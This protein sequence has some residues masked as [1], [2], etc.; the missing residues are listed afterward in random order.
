MSFP[1]RTNWWNSINFGRKNRTL[2]I[3][4][5]R[6]QRTLFLLLCCSF[7]YGLLTAG[8]ANI[9]PP[10]GGKKDETPPVLLSISPADSALNIRPSLIELKFNKFME[11]KDLNKYMQLSPLL[12]IQPTV[13]S[14]LRR[15]E[16]KIVDSLLQPNTTYRIDLGDALVDNREATPYKNFVYLFSTGNY[17]DSLE[18]NGYIVNARTGKADTNALI[19][20]YPDTEPDSAV[21]KSKPLYALKTDTRGRFSIKSLP[22]KPFRIY[23]VQDANNNYLYDPGEEQ[24]GF[25]NYPVLPGIHSDTLYRLNLFK[26]AIDSAAHKTGDSLSVEDKTAGEGKFSLRKRAGGV[27][28]NDISYRVNVDTINK[29][30]RTFEITKPLTIDL[31]TSVNNIDTGKIY[32]SYEDEEVEIEAVHGFAAD[33]NAIHITPQWVGNKSY[34]LRLVKGW[35]TDSSGKE[36]LPGKYSFKTKSEEDYGTLKINIPPLYRGEK[37]RLSVYFKT[38]SVYQKGIVDS[39][40][41]LSLLQPGV[42]SMSI[43]IDENGNGKWD[44]GI[45]LEKKQPEIVIPHTNEITLK[46]GWENEIDFTALDE[47]PASPKSEDK[48]SSPEKLAPDKK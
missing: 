41:R 4:F 23:A 16:I 32:L 22:Y 14:Y 31:Y 34:T 35:A 17:F 18:L 1:N 7:F 42:Y 25:L 38:D 27:G 3:S 44:P 20:L 10:E 19:M 33:S 12:S 24:V 28:K 13:I 15:V 9:V 39:I 26:E 2:Y 47:M 36:L 37:Y 48:D 30:V 46:A 5:E 8:C 43:F 11:I 6:N 40:V 45:L 21:V 29:N